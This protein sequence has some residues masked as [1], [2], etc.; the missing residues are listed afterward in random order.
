LIQAPHREEGD[1]DMSN[2]TGWSRWGALAEALE[3]AFG[4]VEAEDDHLLVEREVADCVVTVRVGLTEVDGAWWVSADSAVCPSEPIDLRQSQNQTPSPI[5][6][7]ASS[8]R[9]GR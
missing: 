9:R 5:T 8:C 2:D 7:A 1:R 6:P 3:E 4:V